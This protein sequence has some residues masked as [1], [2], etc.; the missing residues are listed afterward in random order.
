MNRGDA[1]AVDDDTN[2]GRVYSRFW[3]RC[4]YIFMMTPN[5]EGPI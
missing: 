3:E 1:D 2:D 5:K 4:G